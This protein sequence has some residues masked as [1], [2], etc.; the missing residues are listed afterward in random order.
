MSDELFNIFNAPQE[1]LTNAYK[2]G[3]Q[4]GLDKGLEKNWH[5]NIERIVGKDFT[6]EDIPAFIKEP[7]EA[8]IRQE[9]A[10][11]QELTME[12]RKEAEEVIT[13]HCTRCNEPVKGD[14]NGLCQN[15]V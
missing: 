5:N 15:C 12:L 1:A 4:K 9:E 8:K 13:A 11:A 6:L 14:T 3:F 10:E 7:I 2:Q